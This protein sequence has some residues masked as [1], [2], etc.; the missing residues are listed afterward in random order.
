[1]IQK[2]AGKLNLGDFMFSHPVSLSGYAAIFVGILLVLSSGGAGYG[3]AVTMYLCGV[4]LT[5]IG[6]FMILLGVI[7]EGFTRI[8][9]YLSRHPA[10]KVDSGT[11]NATLKAAFDASANGPK[12][13][14]SMDASDIDDSEKLRRKMMERGFTV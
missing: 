6:A 10:M 5:G 9:G 2:N 3:S 4:G 1:M 12:E 14:R 13:T 8:E 11:V 7:A